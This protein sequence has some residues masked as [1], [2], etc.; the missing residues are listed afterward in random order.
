[1]YFV[2]YWYGPNDDDTALAG[3]AETLEQ[4]RAIAAKCPPD[5]TAYITDQ[6]GWGHPVKA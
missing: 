2:H 6:H 4:A 5:Q 1:M 3:D